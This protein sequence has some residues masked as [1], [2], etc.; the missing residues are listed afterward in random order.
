MNHNKD[1]N[2]DL[3]KRFTS[4]NEFSNKDIDKLRKGVYPY[5]HI[6]GSIVG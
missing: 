6:D 4:T 1:F 3:I 2:N 5:E